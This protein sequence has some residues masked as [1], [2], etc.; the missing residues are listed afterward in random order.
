[1]FRVPGLSHLTFRLEPLPLFPCSPV[2]SASE[3]VVIVPFLALSLASHLFLIAVTGSCS[4]E[5]P[6]Q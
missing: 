1:M 3:C 2:S 4:D 5:V 6:A